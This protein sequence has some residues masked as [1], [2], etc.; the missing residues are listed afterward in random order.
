[1]FAV[2]NRAAADPSSERAKVMDLIPGL[3][4][5]MQVT[6]LRKLLNVCLCDPLFLLKQHEVAS[7]ADDVI[8]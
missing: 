3:H 4:V 2:A 6:E 1:M 8:G 7:K 5:E